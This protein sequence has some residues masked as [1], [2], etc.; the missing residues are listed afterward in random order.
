MREQVRHA[1][2]LTKI[3]MKENEGSKAEDNIQ[4][5]IDFSP[6]SLRNIQGRRS[7]LGILRVIG[8]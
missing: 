3:K 7:H 8:Y 1:P 6:N 2:D 4:G 5:E